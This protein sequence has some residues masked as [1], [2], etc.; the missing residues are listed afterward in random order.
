VFV[1]DIEN[2]ADLIERLGHRLNV[3]RPKR[4]IS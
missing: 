1:G 2:F 3:V 4:P